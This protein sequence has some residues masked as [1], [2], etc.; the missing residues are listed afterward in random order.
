M[1]LRGFQID[2]IEA[3]ATQGD[4]FRPSGGK[5][6]DGFRIDRI[7]DEGADRFRAGGQRGRLGRQAIFEEEETMMALPIGRFQELLVVSFGAENGDFHGSQ[8][9]F[10]I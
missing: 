2:L 8:R 4:Q 3:R 10:P 9:I 1:R 7:V 5:N 6:P